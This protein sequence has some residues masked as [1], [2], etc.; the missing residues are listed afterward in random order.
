VVRTGAHASIFIATCTGR[1]QEAARAL[2]LRQLVGDLL[3]LGGQRLVLDSRNSRAALDNQ[4]IRAVLRTT[5]PEHRPTWYHVDSSTEPIIWV[6][7][8]LG[9]AYGA[10][11]DWRRRAAPAITAVISCD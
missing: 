11:G 10:G 5:A 6:S 2:C 9:W 1:E 7:D 3:A 8:T 4:V